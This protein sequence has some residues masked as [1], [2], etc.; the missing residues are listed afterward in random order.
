MPAP[1]GHKRYGGRVVGSKNQRVIEWE[2]FGKQLLEFGLP[3]A[4]GI[5]ETCEDD[6]FMMYMNQY[7]EYF[8]PKL[9]RTE[10]TGKEGNAIEHTWVI[11]KSEK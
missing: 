8:K 6:D 4:M 9:A 11:P 3:R 2:Q 1:K 10:L 5:M 7:I